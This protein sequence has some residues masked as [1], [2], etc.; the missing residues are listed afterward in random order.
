MTLHELQSSS[1]PPP[2]PP[3]SP[4]QS[5][6]KSTMTEQLKMINSYTQ[7]NIMPNRKGQSYE[8]LPTETSRLARS[9]SFSA[10]Q[11]VYQTETQTDT[12]THSKESHS[13]VHRR[14]FSDGDLLASYHLLSKA[15]N[16]LSQTI[17][18]P[19][20]S[21][22][23]PPPPPPPPA[24]PKSS[25]SNTSDRNNSSKSLEQSHLSCS[26]SGSTHKCKWYAQLKSTRQRAKT[27]MQ[28]VSSSHAYLL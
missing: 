20:P 18:P 17:H 15:L 10:H 13:R 28:Q 21:P 19:H 1:P 12:E 6:N 23:P 27:L 16:K 9:H 26:N 2:P 4:P 24:Q 25:Q 5:L 22:P 7:V 3:P 11:P 14:R 8:N